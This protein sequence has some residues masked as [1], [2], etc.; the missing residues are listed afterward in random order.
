[1]S[2]ST[3]VMMVVYQSVKHLMRVCRGLVHGWAL[4]LKSKGYFDCRESSLRDVCFLLAD[5]G[6]VRVVCLVGWNIAG[7]RFCLGGLF[8]F[9]IYIVSSGSCVGRW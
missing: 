8:A 1:M 4:R 2:G 9:F 3:S 5:E 7:I 6:C